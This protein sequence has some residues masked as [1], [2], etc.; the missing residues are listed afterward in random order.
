MKLSFIFLALILSGCA[1]TEA[2]PVEKI[3][4]R[5]P[6]ETTDP[7]QPSY[8][9]APPYDN[10]FDGV[11]ELMGDREVSLGYEIELR[12]ALKSCK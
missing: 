12:A 8:R 6:C 1:T 4:V 3:P 5:I 10:L 2:P 9:F 11:R 7:I